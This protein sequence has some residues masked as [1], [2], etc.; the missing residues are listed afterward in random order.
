[1]NA[2][3]A[4]E[5]AFGAQFK[6]LTKWREELD[7]VELISGESA[8]LIEAQRDAFDN[9]INILVTRADNLGINLKK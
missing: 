3:E 4:K 5:T 7:S 1:M 2:N 8:G 9:A 6:L